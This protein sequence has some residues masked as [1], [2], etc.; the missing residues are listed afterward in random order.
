MFVMSFVLEIVSH[1]S[2]A[3]WPACAG[4]AAGSVCWPG[5]SS[6]QGQPRH[7]LPGKG[8]CMRAEWQGANVL[9]KA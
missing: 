7:L 9:V 4:P 1:Y 2:H 6:A 3:T 5:H 8:K